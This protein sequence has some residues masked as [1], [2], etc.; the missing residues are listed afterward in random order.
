MCIFNPVL[1]MVALSF[2]SRLVSAPV[3]GYSAPIAFNFG[4]VVFF[5]LS[6]IAFNQ[7]E[8]INS[9]K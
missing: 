5:L 4:M 9:L 2:L 7:G 8:N 6:T 3:G 1:V